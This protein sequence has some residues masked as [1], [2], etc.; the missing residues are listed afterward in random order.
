VIDVRAPRPD[1]FRAAA[2]TVADALMFPRL[3]DEEWGPRSDSW[4][5]SHS[6]TAWDGDRCVGHAGAFH[7]DTTVPGG[8]RLPTS[9]VTRVGV[10][11]THTRRGVLRSMMT[12]L[13]TEARDAGKVLASLR[14]SE[15]VIYERFG[16]G[17][18]GEA[19]DVRIRPR[20]AGG[21]R[22]P[23]EGPMRLLRRD[24]V[25]AVVPDLYDRCGRRRVGTVS[26]PDFLWRRYLEDATTG[27]KP[28]FVAVHEDSTGTPDGYVHYTTGW[29]DDNEAGRGELH[30]LVGADDEVERALWQYLLGI[31]LVTEWVADERPLDEAIRHSLTNP[32]AYTLTKR[33][34]EQWLR[35]LDVDVALA[36]RT[37]RPCDR[38]VTLQITD[39]L[40]SANNGTWRIDAYGSFRSHD[41]PDLQVDI[42]TAS[43]GYLGGTSWCELA[44]A[45]RV[46]ARRSEAVDE[47]DTLF[48][49]RP[50][51]FSGTFF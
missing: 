7:F 20:E 33:W 50:Y 48:A 26:R 2:D 16:F 1:E 18:A 27:K 30:E 8:N 23:A 25:M 17:V 14:A 45:G 3:S 13:L 38:A 32:R 44:D 42:A 35:L 29:N 24:E 4:T 10:L 31:D 22:R 47:A 36:A 6:V 11:S 37:Y 51:P 9:G 15:A 49:T 43:A 19:A 41:E 40:F 28:S 34:D 46:R 39:D 5:E 21:V 12:Q